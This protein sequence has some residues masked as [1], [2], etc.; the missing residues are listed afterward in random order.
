MKPFAALEVRSVSKSYAAKG[1][2]EPI[3]QH[4]SF[5][6]REGEIV[7]ILGQSGCGKSTLLNIIGGFVKPDSGSVLFHGKPADGP[8]RGCVMLFQ[9]YGLLPWRTVVKNVELGLEQ[10]PARERREIALEFLKL[11]GLED[12]AEHFP[13]QLSGGMQQRVALARALAIRPRVL[14]MDEPF[15]ALDTFTRY[16]LQ[17]ELLRIHAKE[18]ATIV[19]VT[20][21]ID[22]AV[23]LSDR[24]LIMSSKPGEIHKEIVVHTSR[25]RDR[26]HED[27]QHY[28]K[29]ILEQFHLTGSLPA[30]EYSI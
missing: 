5:S 27:F 8:N 9:N 2:A 10:L 4:V 28:R 22:E 16:Y 17:N 29:L 7:S 13:H 24:V 26:G 19:F 15:A 14:L 23:Y 3:L 30:E 18:K 12:R 6:V 1:D 20:H 21:D 25:P 11:V